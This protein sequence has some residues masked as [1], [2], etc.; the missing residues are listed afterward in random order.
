V[1]DFEAG[2]Y[3]AELK[4]ELKTIKAEVDKAPVNQKDEK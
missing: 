1:H 2:K 3:Y 4:N